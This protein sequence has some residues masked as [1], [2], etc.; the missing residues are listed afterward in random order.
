MFLIANWKMN[1]SKDLI[2]EFSRLSSN[3]ASEV[4]ICPPF[5]YLDYAKQKLPFSLGAQ[6]CCEM[7]SGAYTGF[8]SAS[9]LSEM[10]VSYALVGHSE[11]RYHAHETEEQIVR[12]S[13]QIQSYGITPIICVGESL[14]VYQSGKTLSFIR[15]QLR[16]YE[17]LPPPYW[18]AY[19]PIWAIGQGKTPTALEV[20]RVHELIDQVLTCPILYGG[21]VSPQTLPGLLQVSPLDGFLVGGQSLSSK[22]FQSLREAIEPTSKD[23]GVVP[24]KI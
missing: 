22:T 11:R 16:S 12:K 21:S 1:G 19:E 20:T 18:V 9:M 17:S 4:I 3:F 23:L 24:N 14:E 13:Q 15:L 10:G 7:N 5:P 2:D 8:V 6:D